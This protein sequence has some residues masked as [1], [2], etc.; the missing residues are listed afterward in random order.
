MLKTTTNITK[1][2]SSRC[3]IQCFIERFEKQIVAYK[4]DER[5][6]THIIKLR[7]HFVIKFNSQVNRYELKFVMVFSI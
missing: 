5:V 1:K 7:T 4:E 2:W 6:N 3:E